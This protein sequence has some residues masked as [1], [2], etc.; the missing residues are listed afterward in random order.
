MSA[1]VWV[2][3][4][5]LWSLSLFHYVRRAVREKRVNNTV[6]IVASI[7]FVLIVAVLVLQGPALIAGT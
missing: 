4:I 3:L 6:K 7:Q 5:I 2:F 1:Y